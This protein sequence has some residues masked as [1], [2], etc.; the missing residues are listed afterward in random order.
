MGESFEKK[1]GCKIW[2]YLF[3]K[4]KADWAVEGATSKQNVGE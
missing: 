1:T 2:H 3:R 4:Y